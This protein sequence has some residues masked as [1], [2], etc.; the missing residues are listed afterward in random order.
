MCLSMPFAV[1]ERP[2]HDDNWVTYR[3]LGNR[4]IFA[5]VFEREEKIWINVKAEPGKG[6]LWRSVFEAVVPA[7]HM[8]KA[9]WISII[10]DG[11]MDDADIRMLINDSFQLTAPRKPRHAKP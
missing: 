2:F 3:H 5:L 8:N 7:Y 6:D 4:K 10:L 11:T 1:E 9:H